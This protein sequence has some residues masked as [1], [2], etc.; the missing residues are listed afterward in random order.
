MNRVYLLRGN[1]DATDEV[2]GPLFFAATRAFTNYFTVEDDPE[3]V[4]C[5]FH[6]GGALP[7]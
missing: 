1:S 7:G 4:V 3:H 5:T 6:G 2:H